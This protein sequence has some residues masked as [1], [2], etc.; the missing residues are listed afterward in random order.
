MSMNKL[1]EQRKTTITL[2]TEVR[3]AI[4]EIRIEIAREI[5]TVSKR[6]LPVEVVLRILL[7]TYDKKFLDLVPE[8]FRRFVR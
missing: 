3:D 7:A 5:G 2:S 6:E 4:E 8:R 1:V